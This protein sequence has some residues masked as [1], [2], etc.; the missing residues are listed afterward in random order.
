M[1]MGTCS[2]HQ[3]LNGMNAETLCDVVNGVLSCM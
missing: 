1:E 3:Y 2:M